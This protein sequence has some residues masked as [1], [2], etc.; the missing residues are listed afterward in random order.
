MPTS[1]LLIAAA[2]L[3]GF[4]LPAVAAEPVSQ[5]TPPPDRCTKT[6]GALGAVMGHSTETSPEGRP[7]YR[8]QLRTNGRDY[9]AICDAQSG[10]VS[11]VVPRATQ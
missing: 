1:K 9:E 11:D 2:L 4:A 3:A 8:F 7:M 6:V 10:V 5:Q